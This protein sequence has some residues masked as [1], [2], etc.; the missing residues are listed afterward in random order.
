[1]LQMDMVAIAFPPT[2][3]VLAMT[4]HRWQRSAL[5]AR[6][7]VDVRARP[8]RR[9]TAKDAV[10]V[11]ALPR[12]EYEVCP[13]FSDLLAGLSVL[14]FAGQVDSELKDN[15]AKAYFSA[16]KADKIKAS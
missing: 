10:S 8:M 3:S 13:V 15:V 9:M 11:A 2:Y 4:C 16:V 1:M 6:L 12:R 14:I 7:C 5:H